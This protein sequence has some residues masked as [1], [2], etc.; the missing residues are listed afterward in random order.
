MSKICGKS[1]KILQNSSNILPKSTK[2]GPKSRKIRPWTVFGAKSRPGNPK[3]LQNRTSE[4]RRTFWTPAG[5]PHGPI[6]APF[7]PKKV[8]KVEYPVRVWASWSRPGRDLAP[9]TVQGR[10]FIDFGTVFGRF[11]MDFGQLWN[12][13]P[14]FCIIATP[15][16]TRIQA[17]TFSIQGCLFIDFECIQVQ[18]WTTTV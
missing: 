15:L 13:F 3:S 12:D 7:S 16:F 4:Y 14:L 5:L 2:N 1:L 9:K 11:R 10:I 6:G 8:P 18:L 17:S